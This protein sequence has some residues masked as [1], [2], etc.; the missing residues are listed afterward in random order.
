MTKEQLLAL[1][2][3]IPEHLSENGKTYT[4]LSFADGDN[5]WSHVWYVWEETQWVR[6]RKHTVPA[7]VKAE[8]DPY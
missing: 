8:F 5:G 6:V 2:A 3:I 1:D 4:V 7:D